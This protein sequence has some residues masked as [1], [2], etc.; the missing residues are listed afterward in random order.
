VVVHR[1]ALDRVML[2]DVQLIEHT[3][4]DLADTHGLR[5][6]LFF[7]ALEERARAAVALVRR[8]SATELLVD[9][10]L[11]LPVFTTK[12]AAEHLGRSRVAVNE[13][14]SRL[15][16]AGVIRKIT[17]GR[18]NRA[19]EAVGL[20]RTSPGSSASSPAPTPTPTPPRSCATF[21]P[22]PTDLATGRC[23]QRR[24]RPGAGHRSG[25]A[26]EER[27]PGSAT[28]LMGC[29]R[30]PTDRGRAREAGWPLDA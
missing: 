23:A 20:S 24:R 2:G 27:R 11:A 10:L 12:I 29:P 7:A 14:I 25:P 13:A 26:A 30:R 17:L 15:E 1:A 5:V 19:V 9:A 21:Q 8:G 18:R 4:P 28:R 22:G 6:F 3:L 16:D